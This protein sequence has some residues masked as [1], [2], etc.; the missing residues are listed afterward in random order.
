VIQEEQIA[1]RLCGVVKDAVLISNGCLHGNC[2]L[3]SV[4]L[5]YM[6]TCRGIAAQVCC[7][8]TAT[9]CGIDE[10]ACAHCWVQTTTLLLDPTVNQ[11]AGR[12][13]DSCFLPREQAGRLYRSNGWGGPVLENSSDITQLRQQLKLTNWGRWKPVEQKNMLQYL[14]LQEASLLDL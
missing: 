8:C 14:S 3:A 4:F 10:I 12:E 2:S 11:F 13:T 9:F 5:Q 1:A 7:G 6:L